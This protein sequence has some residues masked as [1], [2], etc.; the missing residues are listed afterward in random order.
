[1]QCFYPSPMAVTN[2]VSS[3]A[4][5]L[6]GNSGSGHPAAGNRKP[7]AEAPE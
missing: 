7:S 2:M 4:I 5:G 3:I 1:M 6:V